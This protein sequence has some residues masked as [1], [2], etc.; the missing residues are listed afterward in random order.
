MGSGL[1]TEDSSEKRKEELTQENIDST[2]EIVEKINEV[3]ANYI[4]NLSIPDMESLLDEEYCKKV[5]VITSNVFLERVKMHEV[6]VLVQKT[7]HGE[8]VPIKE[9]NDVAIVVHKT[10]EEMKKRERFLKRQNCISIAKFYIKIAHLY[11]AIVKTVDPQFDNGNKD[12][13]SLYGINDSSDDGL[14]KTKE[15][16]D[17][18]MSDIFNGFCFQRIRSLIQLLPT[19]KLVEIEQAGGNIPADDFMNQKPFFAKENTDCDLPPTFKIPFCFMI[20]G[21]IFTKSS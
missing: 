9:T 14:R 18:V 1:S 8:K 16:N 21:N 17:S 2:K 6:D 15:A 19:Y 7:S 4:V 20:L 5:E 13:F 3:A 11:S 12:I 10:P